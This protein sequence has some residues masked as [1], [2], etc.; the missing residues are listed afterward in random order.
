MFPVDDQLLEA[1][2]E[3][4]WD[5]EDLYWIIGGSG[6]GKTTVS[7]A[8][9]AATG[10][11]IYDLDL[12][13]YDLYLPRYDPKR[14]PASTAWFS[15]KDP[16]AWSL[17]L[18][19]QA[20]DAMLRASNIE[21]LDLLAEDLSKVPFC[22]PMVVDGGITHPS[23]L[24][25]AVKSDRIACIDMEETAR[26][27]IWENLPE[28]SSMLDAIRVLPDGEDKWSSFLRFDRLLTQTIVEESR[29]AGIKLIY[30]TKDSPIN[31]LAKRIGDHFGF[32]LPDTD[33][34]S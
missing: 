2:R 4:L 24:V 7:C 9:A 25:R 8:L 15:A 14:H 20:F 33:Q 1:A 31:D 12:H 28:R 13:T 6:T 21:Y 30:R 10:C 19:W 23:L 18:S 11:A 5:R 16:L 32:R 22:S 26:A 29:L 17:S 27:A 34:V 3:F